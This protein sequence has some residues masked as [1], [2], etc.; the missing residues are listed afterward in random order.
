MANDGYWDDVFCEAN[1]LAEELHQRERDNGETAEDRLIEDLATERNELVVERNA[2][3]LRLEQARED[4]AVQA[5]KLAEVEAERQEL[6]RLLGQARKENS[7]LH[8]K[9]ADV[10]QALIDYASHQMG[11]DS[12]G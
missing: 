6:E 8:A 2:L 11:G 12:H 10:E 3:C 1:T 5:S 4:M 9:L 7:R